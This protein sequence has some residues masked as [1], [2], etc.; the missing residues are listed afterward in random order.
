MVTGIGDYQDVL[1]TAYTARV[2]VIPLTLKKV[3]LQSL[4]S[5]NILEVW[6]APDLGKDRTNALQGFVTQG[7]KKSKQVAAI[8]LTDATRSAELHIVV[9]SPKPLDESALQEIT[10]AVRLPL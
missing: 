6:L 9:S 8:F 1:D 10:R 5:V 2:G 4:A 7:T 3:L